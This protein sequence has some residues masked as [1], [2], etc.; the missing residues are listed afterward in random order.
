[1]M[2]AKAVSFF[3]VEADGR[4]VPSDSVLQKIQTGTNKQ[5]SPALSI[6]ST[7]SEEL[8]KALQLH[9][10]TTPSALPSSHTHIFVIGTGFL[11]IALACV[12]YFF[13]KRKK[14]K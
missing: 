3:V 1:M 5:L 4:K 6:D 12:L 7:N 9:P 2:L 10:S 11:L 13:Q 8:A 14:A